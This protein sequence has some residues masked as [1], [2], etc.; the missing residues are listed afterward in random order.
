CLASGSP[1][2]GDLPTD[3]EMTSV[4]NPLEKLLRAGEGR[5]IRRLNQVVK[6]V[7]ALEEDISKLTDD[8][9]RN[10]TTELRARYEK[11]EALDQLMPEAF[12][13][14]REA[15]K[16]TLGMRAYAVQIVGG[17]DLQRRHIAD[18]RPCE[19]HT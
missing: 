17:A 16:R 1:A 19:G 11:G 5:V 3:R 2:A 14:V 18:M 15:A 12:A 7:G 6:A 10:E 13:A 4:A 9:L 8:E